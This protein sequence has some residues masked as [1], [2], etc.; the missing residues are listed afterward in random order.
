MSISDAFDDVPTSHTLLVTVQSDGAFYQQGLDAIDSLET[1]DGVD[2][3]DTVS[4]ASAASLFETFNP[5]TIRLLETV[6]DHEPAS[7]RETA[8]LVDRDVSNV[9]DELSELHRLGF[10]TFEQDGRAKRPVFPY[11]KLLINLPF[12]DDDATDSASARS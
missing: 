9:H 4:F 12:A 7:I 1:G 6:V 10:V 8:R 3:P 5:R 2:T 11:D